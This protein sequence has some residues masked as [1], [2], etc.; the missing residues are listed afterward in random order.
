MPGIDIK[1]KVWGNPEYM[2]DKEAA[3]EVAGASDTVGNFNV[4]GEAFLLVSPSIAKRQS[5][6][7]ANDSATSPS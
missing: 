4:G 5:Q 6:N 7:W 1:G 2:G 3:R